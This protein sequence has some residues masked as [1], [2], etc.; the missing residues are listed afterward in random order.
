MREY[1][2]NYLLASGVGSSFWEL[3]AFDNALISAGISN[4]NLLKVSSILP[5]GCVERDGLTLLEG[6]AVLTSYGTISSNICGEQIASA[7]AVGI[8]ADE[9]SVGVI[10]EYAGRCDAETAET[11]A[12]EMVREA[13]R[14]HGIRCREI[15]SNSAEA[16]AE[17]GAYTTVISALV[18]W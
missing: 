5:A 6:S 18:F 15:K 14:N 17:D 3:V 1:P 16:I 10:M 7:V 12:R 13:M 4:Y 11:V 2:S 9:D 8:P